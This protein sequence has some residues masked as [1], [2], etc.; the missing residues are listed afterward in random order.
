MVTP[1]PLQFSDRLSQ[2]TGALVYLKRE[3]L[4]VVRSY[5]LRGAYNLLMQL[6]PEE[7]A[8]G[9]VCSSAGNHAQGFAL[10]CRSMGIHG[11]VYVPAKTPK[12]KRDR[13]RYHGGEFIELIVGGATYD[14]ATGRVTRVAAA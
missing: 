11:R 10:A 14:L 8:A 5:K 7:K 9:V 13:I 1:T 12:Q 3:D 2:L 4:Q 6:T